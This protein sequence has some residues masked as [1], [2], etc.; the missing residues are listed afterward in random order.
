M[1]QYGQITPW[2]V[3]QNQQHR[4]ADWLGYSGRRP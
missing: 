4:D 1:N 2:W 3:Q